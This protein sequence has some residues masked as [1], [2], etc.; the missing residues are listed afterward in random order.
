MVRWAVTSPQYGVVE[1]I[2]DDGSG[3]VEWWVDYVEVVAPTKRQAIVC[4]VQKMRQ[5]YPRGWHND[6]PSVNPF[7]GMKAKRIDEN[8]VDVGK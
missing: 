6:D 7:A 4:G 2:L 8:F 1:P 3:P 5:L